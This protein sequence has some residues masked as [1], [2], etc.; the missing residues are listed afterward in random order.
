MTLVQGGGW[1]EGRLLQKYCIHTSCFQLLPM[2]GKAHKH[3]HTCR[4][5]LNLLYASTF[6]CRSSTTPRL[7]PLL[8]LAAGPPL[9]PAALPAVGAAALS[10]CCSTSGCMAAHT[11][12]VTV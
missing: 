9:P 1:S 11:D 4:W 8:L 2:V 3:A 7:V 5:C 12:T 10:A 6:S